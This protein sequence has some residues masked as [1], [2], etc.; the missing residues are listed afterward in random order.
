M[1]LIVLTFAFNLLVIFNSWFI[2]F[3]DMLLKIGIYFLP[4]N[5][6]SV[7]RYRM[8]LSRREFEICIWRALFSL[9]DASLSIDS[10][11]TSVKE[12]MFCSISSERKNLIS[13]EMH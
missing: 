12:P 4:S 7:L 1:I 10:L 3:I 13:S 5:M 6:V 2:T 9:I 11:I 8:T